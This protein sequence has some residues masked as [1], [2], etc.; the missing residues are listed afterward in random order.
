MATPNGPFEEG[1]LAFT[2]GVSI[3]DN[4]YPEW[5]RDQ[6]DDWV[7]G[8]YYAEDASGTQSGTSILD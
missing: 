4:P 8:W 2:E 5:A 6:F 7:S 1:Y 3:R